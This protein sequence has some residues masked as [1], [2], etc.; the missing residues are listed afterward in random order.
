MVGGG[1]VAA[2][3]ARGLLDAGAA[4]VRCVAPEFGEGFPDVELVRANYGPAHLDGAGLVF[5]ATDNAEVNAAVVRDARRLG[6]LVN[7]ADAD[8]DEPG[9]FATPAVL[10]EGELTLTVSAGGSPALAAV[11]RDGLRTRLD[12]RWVKMA[13]AMKSLRPRITGRADIAIDRRRRMFQELASEEALD[14]LD[15][16]GAERLWTWL[17]GRSRTL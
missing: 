4:G 16:S 17:Q 5:A 1:G 14:V 12:A 3:K 15:R 6:L 13:D 10:R 8:E 7:R 11:I 9:D 2:R